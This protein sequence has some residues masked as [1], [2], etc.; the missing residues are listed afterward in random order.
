MHVHGLEHLQRLTRS[1]PGPPRDAILAS[2]ITNDLLGCS[3]GCDQDYTSVILTLM[4][5]PDSALCEQLARLF[6]TFSSLASGRSYLSE[7][8]PIILALLEL[9]YKEKNEDTAI[10]RNALGAIQK[11]SLR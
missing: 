4:K 1:L 9:L 10:R 6:N 11:L 8:T 7:A 3:R 2:Y 5:S